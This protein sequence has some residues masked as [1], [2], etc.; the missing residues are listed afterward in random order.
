MKILLIGNFAPPYEE[1]SLYNFSLL[2]RL[3]NDGDDCCVINISEN[4]SREEGII[5]ISGYPDYI[6][7]LVRLARKKDVIHFMTKGYTRLGLL[8][9]ALSVMFGSLFR[10]KP[11]VTFHSELLSIIGLTRS[12]FGGQQTVN[13]SF[14]RAHKVIFADRDT[15]DI[16]SLYR[17]K[18]NFTLI[19]SSIYISEE[20]K[21]TYPLVFKKLINK[22]KVIV[23]SNV[24]YPSFLFEI[25]KSL[26]SMPAHP[27]MGII[28]SLSEKPSAKLQ[29]AI[30]EFGK[31]WV[32]NMAFIESD[33]IK[34]LTAAYSKA[35]LILKP[36]TCDGKVFFPGFTVSLKRP[37]RS[38]DYIY[39]PDSLLLLKEGN[40]ADLCAYIVDTVL[41]GRTWTPAEEV[42]SEDFYSL[43]KGIYAG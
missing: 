16:A 11:V 26:L 31:D 1:E 12:P 34:M 3:R 33:N 37:V 29:H 18:D 32:E 30:E 43:I 8:K 17:T 21:G 10:A 42:S 38:D 22:K 13:F 25:L 27:D 36:L 7:K 15:C 40:A 4:P 5:D 2:N 14:S 39:F 23:F 41:M 20:L 19:P 6:S 9:L 24:S 28:I 35:N